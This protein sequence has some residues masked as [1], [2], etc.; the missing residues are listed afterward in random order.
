MDFRSGC[1]LGFL[2]P[3]CISTLPDDLLLLILASL[4]CISVRCAQAS[5]QGDGS[6]L[7]QISCPPAVSLL[8]IRAPRQDMASTAQVNS[9]LSV[10]AEL[11]PKEFVASFPSSMGLLG[12]SIII[13]LPCFHRTTSIMLD[14]VFIRS[15]PV[16]VEF[17]MLERLSLLHCNGNLNALLS[18]CPRLCTLLLSGI[19]FET[20]DL[21][22]NSSSLQE[23]VVRPFSIERVNII[24]PMLKKLEILFTVML[25]VNISV[26]APIMEK[27]WWYCYYTEESI[28]F[29]SLVSQ[30]AG[31][32]GGR[33]TRTT[34]SAAYSCKCRTSA[35]LFNLNSSLF[36]DEPN[37]AEEIEK[38][39]VVDFSLLELDLKTDGHVFGALVFYLLNINRISSSLQRLKIIL[40]RSVIKEKCPTDCPC[41]FTNWRSR[42]ISLTALEEVEIDGF[43]GV[44][45]EFDLLKLLL[46][47]APM[48]K[49][50][51]VR[52]SREA[53]TSNTRCTKINN[54]F[55]TYG[56]TE[57]FV[58]LSS[59]LMDNIQ[60]RP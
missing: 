52:L 54:I 12:K 32:A 35:L 29:L 17:P 48:L 40:L 2:D 44:D 37:F 51:I 60:N 50:I 22:V 15:V 33:E 6:A 5:S 39:M 56:S 13:D 25:E 59:G 46:V 21:R 19:L 11:E 31:T 7:D 9:L 27:V 47:S 36:S 28:V 41:E 18:C 26:F 8:E 34:P 57:C 30:V 42:P 14:H 3:N 53:S 49:K 45:H 20:C 10:A 24:A 4:P 58:Y 43:E 16:S 23:L 38:H 1:H 55:G